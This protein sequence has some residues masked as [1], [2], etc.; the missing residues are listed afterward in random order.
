VFAAASHDDEL[1]LEGLQLLLRVIGDEA[2][3]ARPVVRLPSATAVGADIEDETKAGPV[4]FMLPGVECISSILE[5]LTKN[6][7]YQTI[8]LQLGY[9]NTGCTVRDMAESLL[10]VC[11]TNCLD[12]IALL[13]LNR[14]ISIE[15]LN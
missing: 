4:L 9:S 1:Q 11:T 5:P 12:N 7:K 8:C 3:A 15:C 10:P 13:W 14:R 6:L 2:T